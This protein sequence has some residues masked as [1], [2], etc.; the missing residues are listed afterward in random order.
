[1]PG[2]PSPGP[3]VKTA[4]GR[5]RMRGGRGPNPVPG[6]SGGGGDHDAG[7]RDGRAGDRGRRGGGRGRVLRAVPAPPPAGPRVH[8]P[9][10]RRGRRRRRYLVLEPLPRGPLRRADHG[11]RLRLRPRARGG[12]EVEREVRHSARDPRLPRVRGRPLR[13]PAGHRVLDPGGVGRLGRGDEA[14]AR[15][16]RPGPSP[17]ASTSWPAGAC[18]G[19]SRWTSPASTGSPARST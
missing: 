14:L 3:V 6:A 4:A 18:P 15:A 5:A 12:V 16:D 8:R 19:P 2:R 17:A 9:G 10:G 7:H 11:L 1:M 13:P